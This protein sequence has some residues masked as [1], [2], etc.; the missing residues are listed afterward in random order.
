MEGQGGEAFF[1]SEESLVEKP[2]S[3]LFLGRVMKRT[4]E[5]LL[6]GGGKNS[7]WKNLYLNVGEKFLR[8]G[9]SKEGELFLE[10]IVHQAGGS[11]GMKKYSSPDKRKGRE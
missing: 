11:W 6:K 5:F 1:S 4:M 9:E 7:H 3:P 8:L 10:Q 2:T